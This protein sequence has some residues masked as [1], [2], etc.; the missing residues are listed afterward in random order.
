MSRMRIAPSLSR[1][2]SI[3]PALKR[4]GANGMSTAPHRTA[5]TQ[6]SAMSPPPSSKH[7][8]RMQRVSMRI[9]SFSSS[10]FAAVQT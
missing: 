2:G 5:L 10:R 9:I 7:L 8:S 6:P 4:D 3:L 1:A